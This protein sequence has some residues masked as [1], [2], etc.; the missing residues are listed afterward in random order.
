MQ[1]CV[2]MWAKV[3]TQF[4]ISWSPNTN[5]WQQYELSQDAP[6]HEITRKSG[7]ASRAKT[8]CWEELW[9]EEVSR[10]L[11]LAKTQLQGECCSNKRDMLEKKKSGCHKFVY[12]QFLVMKYGD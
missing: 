12:T 2:H 10:G 4:Q 11:V 9:E 7:G 5:I 6:E 8:P 3:C 1:K